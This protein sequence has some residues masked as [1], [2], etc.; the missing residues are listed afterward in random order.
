MS[1]TYRKDY[2]KVRKIEAFK[3]LK[4]GLRMYEIS[5]ILNISRSTIGK[6]R[7]EYELTK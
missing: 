1:T 4:K 6:W 3:L 7:D 5:K 2:Y